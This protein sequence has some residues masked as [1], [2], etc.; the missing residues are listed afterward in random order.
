MILSFPDLKPFIQ[1]IAIKVEFRNS[2]YEPTGSSVVW[3]LPTSSDS[4]HT[5]GPFVLQAH[6]LPFSLLTVLCFLLIQSL[7]MCFLAVETLIILQVCLKAFPNPQTRRKS[8]SSAP[9]LAPLPFLLLPWHFPPPE[10]EGVKEGLRR[11]VKVQN[12]CSGS[13]QKG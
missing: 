9:V 1:F 5:P 12:S 4:S 6:W 2:Y 8:P 10:R 7:H 11:G 3:F 13:G